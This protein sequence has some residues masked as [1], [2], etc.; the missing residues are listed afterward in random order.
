MIVSTSGRLRALLVASELVPWVSGDSASSS[1]RGGRA[2]DILKVSRREATAEA[3]EGRR[4][5]VSSISS[6][7]EGMMW[8]SGFKNAVNALCS[9]TLFRISKAPP[10]TQSQDS[11]TPK[12]AM[13][14][15]KYSA[16]EANS[17]EEALMYSLRSN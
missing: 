15:L 2:K 11:N 16:V 1:R 8:F 14:V 12:T 17:E 10:P 5:G 7:D 4:C 6:L 3:K 9:S 13:R